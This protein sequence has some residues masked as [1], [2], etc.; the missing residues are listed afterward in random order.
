MLPGMQLEQ[1]GDVQARL[2]R[3]EGQIRGIQ[4]MIEDGRECTDVVTQ[5]AA[6]LGALQQAGFKYFAATMTQCALDPERAA[7]EGYTQARL[8]KM[9]LQL[10]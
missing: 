9:F 7:D 6:A 2:R 8:E 5:F 1:N 3:V 4:A 10:A